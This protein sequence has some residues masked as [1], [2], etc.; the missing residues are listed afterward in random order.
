MTAVRTI[1]SCSSCDGNPGGVERE[2]LPGLWDTGC[3][4]PTGLSVTRPRDTFEEGSEQNVGYRSRH[5]GRGDELC[6]LRNAPRN[7]VG[8]PLL[9]HT[10]GCETDA[11]MAL[12]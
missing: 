12:A 11:P 3:Q 10:A 6:P 5:I 9:S 8:G 1:A 2:R 7:L 4:V